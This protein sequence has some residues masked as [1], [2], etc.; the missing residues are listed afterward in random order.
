MKINIICFGHLWDKYRRRSRSLMEEIS[1]KPEVNNILY[2]DPYMTFGSFLKYLLK[3]ADNEATLGWQR[4]LSKGFMTEYNDKL[5]LCGSFMP[6]SSR[7]GKFLYSLSL[8]MGA[9]LRLKKIKKWLIANNNDDE[10]L[11][12]WVFH[13]FNISDI[14]K[15]LP[16][17][18]LI[19]DQAED[20]RGKY[21]DG[22]L[23]ETI[24]DE[25]LWLLKNA[26]VKFTANK[27]LGEGDFLPNGTHKIFIEK[28]NVNNRLSHIPHPC[29]L[30]VGRIGDEIIDVKALKGVVK[31]NP[32][33]HFVMV[34]PVDNTHKPI[35]GS[36]IH[37]LGDHPATELPCIIHNA[38]ILLSLKS[39]T[40]MNKMCHS[41]KVFM[42]FSSGKDIV[43]TELAG[44]EN[45]PDLVSFYT[46]CDS[47]SLEIAI[48]NV[49]DKVKNDTCSQK[50]K[51]IAAS[52]TWDKLAEKAL[53]KIIESTEHI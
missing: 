36:N 5:I 14:I 20:F 24:K 45:Y 4:I 37:Y 32:N 2:F 43:A 28:D 19:F 39:A 27:Q 35:D 46:P 34:G 23:K 12:I 3:K 1:K 41:L 15:M 48:R 42:Y 44:F 26:D 53:K 8:K 49:L 38:D 22:W 18:I 51:E 29:I 31:N 30:F 25:H 10:L 7:H 47:E 16:K 40:Y 17:N 9:Y 11:L 50:R 33:W 21:E 6:F 13:P 52:N